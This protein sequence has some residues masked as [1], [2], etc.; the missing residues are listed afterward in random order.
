MTSMNGGEDGGA[1][2]RMIAALGVGLVL[3]S[4]ASDQVSAHSLE[5]LE[6]QLR[7]KEKYFQPLDREVPEFTLRDADGR[8]IGSAD[9]R[10]KVVVLHFVYTNCPDVCPLHAERIAEIQG[11]INPT[12]MRDLVRFVTI[13][14]DPKNDT[15]EVMR[16]YGRER[17]LDPV[18]W[19]FLTSG[20]ERITAT[21]EV[22]ER[23]GHK[24]TKVEDGYQVHGVV[25]HVID[26]EGR[27][28]ANFHGLK[29]QPTNLVLFVNALT[30]DVHK[31]RDNRQR[32]F[33]DKVRELF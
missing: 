20:P 22:V 9:L 15:P 11:M 8:T 19:T 30:N 14:T 29:F 33:W 25:T 18:N 13:T 3:F 7:N 27:W 1:V 2:M 5:S 21:Q 24:F 26:M 16:S 10:G 17:G 12:P 28:R 4:A 32:S 31:V 23:F 6:N